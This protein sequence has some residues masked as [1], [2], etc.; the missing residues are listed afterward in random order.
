MT[1][2]EHARQKIDALMEAAGWVIQDRKDF[3]RN[4]ARG[5]AVRE[6][7]LPNGPCDYLLFVDGK[8]PGAFGGWSKSLM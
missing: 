5:V 7:P 2:E 3:N 6:F 8:A 1:P 4:A